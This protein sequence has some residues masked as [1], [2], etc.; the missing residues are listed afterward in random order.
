MHAKLHGLDDGKK[1]KKAKKEKKKRPLDLLRDG[2]EKG[3]V[4][5]KRGAGDDL[6]SKKYKKI[7]N[8]NS[9]NKITF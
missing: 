5:N 3:V 7:C 6:P 8:E 2:F 4:R 9:G 1:E